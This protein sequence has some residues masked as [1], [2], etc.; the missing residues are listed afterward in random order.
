[1]KAKNKITEY[2]LGFDWST[3]PKG[4]LIVDVGCGIG[5]V[6]LEVAKIRPD[7]QIV[8]QDRPQVIEKTRAVSVCAL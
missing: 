3:V 6:S 4:G 8:L 5:N 1:M 2:F 7:L